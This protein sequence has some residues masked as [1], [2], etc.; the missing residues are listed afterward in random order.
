MMFEMG[1]L[2]WEFIANV[3]FVLNL[4]AAELFQNFNPLHAET[5]R[6]FPLWACPHR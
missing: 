6:L 5:S 2:G 1:F 4:F 3:G